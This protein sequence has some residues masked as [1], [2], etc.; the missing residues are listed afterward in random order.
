MNRVRAGALDFL[1]CLIVTAAWA[2]RVL[3]RLGTHLRDA[4]D[5]QFQAWGVAWV[6]HALLNAPLHLFDANI[7]APVP[8]TLAFTEPL[9]GYGLLGIPLALVGLSPVGVFNALC[10]LGTAFSIWAISRLAIAHGALRAPALL[11]ASAAV[12][13]A[14]AVA[15]LG[16][17]SFV[18][19]GGIALSLVAWKNLRETGRWSSAA[20]LAAGLAGLAWFS[21][22]LFAFGLAA[23]ATVV[24]ID[25][26]AKRETRHLGLLTKLAV[27]LVLAAALVAPLAVHMLEARRDHGFKRDDTESRLYSASPRDWLTTTNANPGQAFLPWRSDSERSLYP[28]TA[29]LV[30]GAL[31]FLFFLSARKRGGLVAAGALLAGLGIAG[32]F[33]PAGPVVP[34]LKFVFPFVFSGIRAFTRFGMVAQI[35]FGLLAAAGTAALLERVHARGARAALVAALALGIA[36]DVRHTVRFEA[37][38]ELPPPPVERFLA[39]GETGGPILHLPLYLSP[40]D[41]RWIFSSVPHFKP[42]VNGYASYVPRRSQE[43]ATTLAAE[44]IPETTLAALKAWPVGTLVV[45]EHALPLERLGPTMAFLAKALRTG[46][47]GPPLHFDHRGGDDWVF[48]LARTSSE[49]GTSG[50]A[51]RRFLA[52]ADSNPPVERFEESD[53]PASI[54][55]PAEGQVVRGALTVRG[56]SQT[57]AGP[58][59][60]VEI[61]VDRDRRARA[62]F[63]RVPRPDVA[64]ALPTL[65]SCAEAGYEA[66]FPMLSGDDGRHDVRVLFRAAD[67]RFRTLTRSFEWE[68]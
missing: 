8:N 61:R 49:D 47:L 5:A 7:F 17:V 39:R 26:V 11:G 23:L 31:G 12:L 16:Y 68:P 35:G 33:G 60:I 43:L 62:S 32:S 18:A 27:S 58:V 21:L 2:A 54:D 37:R 50:E 40:G 63:A 48:S 4:Y 51:A 66:V 25:A 65:G 55:E 14:S 6:S 19:F 52:R 36:L 13:G 1:V 42:I 28:G 9:A 3:P 56:W 44:N 59:E 20:A 15:N 64:A 38:P 30:L 67:G 57:P 24:A 53:F 22:Q 45:H 46:S 29:A 34:L 41:A 10:L